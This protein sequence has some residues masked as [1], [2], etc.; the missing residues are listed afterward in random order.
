M[1]KKEM[2]FL[3]SLRRKSNSFNYNSFE[4]LDGKCIIMSRR[5]C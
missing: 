2:D 1:P 4:I 5:K 3:K